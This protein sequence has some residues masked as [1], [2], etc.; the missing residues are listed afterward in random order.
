[1]IK[2]RC[3]LHALSVALVG[4]SSFSHVASGAGDAR[5]GAQVFQACMACH[6]VKPGEHMTGPSLAGIGNR[7]A[8]TV[9]DF[10][11]YSDAL[12][13]SGVVWNRANLDK[14][15]ANPE[16]FMPGNSMTFPGLQKPADRQDLIAY[17]KAV[18]E[19]KAP[20]AKPQGRGRMMSGGKLD[21]K[22]APPE[23]QVTSIGHCRDTYTVQ[24]GDGKIQ[25]VWEFNLR[26]KTDSSKH[27]PLPGKPAIVGAGM[28]GDR[29]SIVFATPAEIGNSIQSTCR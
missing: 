6:S 20:A 12:K 8:G 23:G 17:L 5:R 18:S 24:T 21:L 4:A 29:A 25:K 1:M 15:L 26:F 16:R 14:W 9:S 2:R 10:L 27:G 7:K 11:R 13:E 28:Q 19:S 3:S 22:Q